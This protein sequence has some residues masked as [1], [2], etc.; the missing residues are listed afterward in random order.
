MTER[1]KHTASFYSKASY[2]DYTGL[3]ELAI[4]YDIEAKIKDSVHYV[5]FNIDYVMKEIGGSR[6][7]VILKSQSRYEI[8][9]GNYGLGALYEIMKACVARLRKN[10][11][12]QAAKNIRIPVQEVRDPSPAD[13]GEILERLRRVLREVG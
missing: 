12:D 3:G 2:P 1:L 10:L 4:E 6:K 8:M 13:M 7:W 11:A 9:P 5:W